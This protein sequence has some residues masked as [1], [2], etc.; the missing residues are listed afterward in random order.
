M[1]LRIVRMDGYKDFLFA[2]C[3]HVVVW[4]MFFLLRAFDFDIV[5]LDKGFV[6][7]PFLNQQV[8]MEKNK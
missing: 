4:A 6:F 8:K 7:H 1:A 5:L 2:F 3:F